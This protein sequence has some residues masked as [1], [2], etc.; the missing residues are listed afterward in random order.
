MNLSAL[1]Q[2]PIFQGS[3]VLAGHSGMNR[4]VRSVNMMDAPDIIDFLKEDELLLTTGYAIKEHPEEMLELVR[5]MAV[6]QCAGLAVKTKRFLQEIPASV[7]HLANELQFPIIELSLNHSL[8]EMVGEALSYI[9]EKRNEELR[10][11]L[12]MH[13]EF[14]QMVLKG[15]GIPSILK[16]LSE[17]TKQSVLLIDSRLQVLAESEKQP[18]FLYRHIQQPAQYF[19]THWQLLRTRPWTLCLFQ[20]ETGQRQELLFYPLEITSHKRC[21]LLFVNWTIETKALPLLAIEQAAN[22]IGFELMKL[23]A[24]KERSMRYKNDFFDDLVE[25]NFQS[26][27]EIVR[28][29]RRY[30]LEE[31]YPCLCAVGKIDDLPEFKDDNLYSKRD[32]IYDCLKDIVNKRKL[33]SIVFIKKDLFVI[34]IKWERGEMAAEFQI[35][36]FFIQLQEQL[37]QAEQIS[38]SFGIG[39]PT[40]QLT[41]IPAAFKEAH[42]ALLMGYQLKHSR[43]VQS[44]RVK[45]VVDLMKM[46][47]QD[48][49][50]DFYRDSFQALLD[51]EEHERKELMNT[52]KVFLEMQCQIT[53]TSKRLFIHRNTVAYRLNKFEQLTCRSLRDPNDSLRLRLAYLIE[54]VHYQPIAAPSLLGSA[55]PLR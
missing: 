39:N 51:L 30:G 36:E 52:A 13:R 27:S 44:F 21:C 2:I 10:H 25:G 8:G 38:L 3:R 22:V 46:I 7:L 45:E 31:T 16:A 5:N 19:L 48:V 4:E 28:Q 29:G 23:Q 11:A 26:A 37:Y 12:S 32:H 49:L 47:P 14:S 43:F 15:E 34:L 50:H 55:P 17:L 33:P 9:M 20:A 1:F 35:R 54:N 40:D 41:S 6:H 42:N 18:D 53:E 24:V